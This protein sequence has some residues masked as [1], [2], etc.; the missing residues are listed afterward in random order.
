M[1][2]RPGERLLHRRGQDSYTYAI[3]PYVGG[4]DEDEL[5]RKFERAAATLSF[6]IDDDPGV[7]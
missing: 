4:A 2:V 1:T 6:E 5:T 3:A 7:D